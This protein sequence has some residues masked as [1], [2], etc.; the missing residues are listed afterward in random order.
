MKAHIKHLTSVLERAEEAMVN[1]VQPQLQLQL[2]TILTG[3]TCGAAVLLLLF[4]CVRKLQTLFP[5]KRNNTGCTITRRANLMWGVPWCV[6]GRW[7]LTVFHAPA[8]DKLLRI[9]RDT[10]RYNHY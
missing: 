6:V 2:N 10:V 9:K 1:I 5:T 7:W 3:I 8:L 4:E